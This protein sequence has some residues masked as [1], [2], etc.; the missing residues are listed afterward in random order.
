MTLIHMEEE[1]TKNRDSDHGRNKKVANRNP[2][3]GTVLVV[4][5]E[6]LIRILTESFLEQLGYRV[7]LADCGEAAV[8][9]YRDKSAQIQLVLS[10]ITMPGIDGI[11][12]IRQLRAISPEL[13]AILSSGYSS[14]RIDTLPRD[15][16]FLAKP[17]SITELRTAIKKISG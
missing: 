1:V 12:T 10:D 17:Y 5:D 6:E 4:D 14:E 11:E 2:A 16:V 3:T 15:T 9:I 13:K 8:K 7:L